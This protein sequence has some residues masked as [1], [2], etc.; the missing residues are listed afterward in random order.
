ME[1]AVHSDPAPVSRHND[2]GGLR[3]T[4]RTVTRHL[5]THRGRQS[6]HQLS[7]RRD[8]A[9]QSRPLPLRSRRTD[10]LPS[11]PGSAPVSRLLPTTATIPV[12]VLT[13]FIPVHLKTISGRTEMS[14]RC[15]KSVLV[16]PEMLSGR[17]KVISGSPEI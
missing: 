11:Q 3:Q 12:A 8:R 4:S 14:F 16:G 15:T 1:T 10:L 13:G 6:C 5:S 2:G 9:V 17:T 7:L